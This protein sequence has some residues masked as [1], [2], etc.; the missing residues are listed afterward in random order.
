MSKL[1]DMT[2]QDYGHWHVIERGPNDKSGRARW[3]CECTL[4]GTKKYVSGGHLRSGR[5]TSCGCTKME[6]MRQACIKHEEGKTY[7]W[8]HV[9]RMATEEEKPRHDRTGVYWVCTCLKC[10]RKNVVVFGDY[11]RNGDTTSCGCVLSVNESRIAQMLDSMNFSYKQQ[12]SFEQLTSTGRECDRLLFDFAIFNKEQLVYLIEYDGIQHF[13]SKHAWKENGFETT[14]K[15]D[16]LKNQYCFENNIPLIRIPYNQEYNLQDL[17][18]AT[19][20][21]LLTPD[22]EKEYYS[23]S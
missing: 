2:G 3:L 22:N 12:F 10:G 9:E 17:K 7:G 8:L 16:L 13:N 14:R 19:T 15:N 11:L 1:I 4:C 5:S 6:K 18:L 23:I 21:F 20:R